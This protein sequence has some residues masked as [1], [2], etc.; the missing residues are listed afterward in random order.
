MGLTLPGL[1]WSVS[2]HAQ[3]DLNI[4]Y[5]VFVCVCMYVL[6]GV[7][8]LTRDSKGRREGGEN[9]RKRVKKKT[10]ELPLVNNYR[11]SYTIT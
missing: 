7:K 6:T 8:E 11:S 4:Y 5:V 10:N 3:A 9:G 2:K 1:C